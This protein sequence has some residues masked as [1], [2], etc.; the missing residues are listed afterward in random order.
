MQSIT[1]K[2]LSVR[3]T[4]LN[5][6]VRYFTAVFERPLFMINDKWQTSDVNVKLI[7]RTNI[8]HWNEFTI[9]HTSLKWFDFTV[10]LVDTVWARCLLNHQKSAAKIQYKPKCRRF[11]TPNG[12]STIAHMLIGWYSWFVFFFRPSF[13][14]KINSPNTA[15][16]YDIIVNKQT[17]N[18]ACLRSSH[19]FF[20]FCVDFNLEQWILSVIYF[21]IWMC[22]FFAVDSF[23]P[24]VDRIYWTDEKM[25]RYG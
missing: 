11:C 23:E 18:N 16:R 4:P 10:L 17:C 15:T 5:R 13:T 2:K 8:K 12:K 3:Q 7:T 6:V 21:I 9:V 1:T 14:F 25:C 22:S 24:K 20:L 19:L